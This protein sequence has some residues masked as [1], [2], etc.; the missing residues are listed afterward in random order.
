LPDGIDLLEELLII[1][2]CIILRRFGIL[3]R[4]STIHLLIGFES[5]L[6]KLDMGILLNSLVILG[7]FISGFVVSLG[8]LLECLLLSDLKL[9]LRQHVV[10]GSPIKDLE[11]L[12]LELLAIEVL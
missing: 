1:L 9:I 5:L 4:R 10:H 6:R 2:I 3:C 8:K 7:N 11:V 12:L